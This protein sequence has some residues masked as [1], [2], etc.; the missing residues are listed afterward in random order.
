MFIFFHTP[1]IG[2]SWHPR[3]SG[4]NI[5]SAKYI[6]LNPIQLHLYV[7]LGWHTLIYQHSTLFW[8]FTT[9]IMKYMIFFFQILRGC[10]KNV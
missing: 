5:Y 9:M 1:T 10:Y 2:A 7:Q 6:I 3:T 4:W 8:L